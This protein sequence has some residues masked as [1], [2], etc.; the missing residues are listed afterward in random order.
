MLSLFSSVYSDKSFIY[1]GLG[2][3]SCSALAE[4]YQECLSELQ[5]G[6]RKVNNCSDLY[7]LSSRSLYQRLQVLLFGHLRFYFF[8]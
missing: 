7:E 1:E 2:V 6:K 5:S 4:S 3:T 8:H